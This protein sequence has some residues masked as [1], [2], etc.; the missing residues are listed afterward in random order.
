MQSVP[1]AGGRGSLGFIEIARKSTGHEYLSVRE[2]TFFNANIIY[3]R[4]CR[5]VLKCMYGLKMF[6]TQQRAMY[7]KPHR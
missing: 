4:D 7:F 5:Y 1:G 2:G 6:N 3:D